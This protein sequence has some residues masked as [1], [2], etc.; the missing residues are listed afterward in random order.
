MTSGL[1]LP[2]GRGDTLLAQRFGSERRSAALWVVLWVLAAAATFGALAPVL[3]RH[4]PFEPVDVVF[5]I[6]GGVVR[7]LRAGRLAP[8]PRQPQ[9]PAHDRHRLRALRRRRCS[10]Q[11]DS[12]LAQTL[13]LLL[14]DL[15]VLF[16]VAARADPPDRRPDADRG[17]TGSSSAPSSR[18]AWCSPRCG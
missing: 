9:R 3:F 17:P 7:G 10:A 15:W 16:F 12:P 13:A 18:A 5:R 14:P 2:R 8:T 4:V 1:A 11:L 6:V